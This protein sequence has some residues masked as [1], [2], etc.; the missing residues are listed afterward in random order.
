MNI[1]DPAGA[2]LGIG[3]PGPAELIIIL[4]IVLVVFGH[5]RIP[6][7]GEALGKGI[8]NFKKSFDK[9]ETEV[10]PDAVRV[11]HV[12]AEEPSTTSEVV[13]EEEKN[14]V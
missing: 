12:A 5:N 9:D 10:Q 11:K 8:K 4:V 14:E 2:L 13:T 3:M 6:Q 1:F 7:L